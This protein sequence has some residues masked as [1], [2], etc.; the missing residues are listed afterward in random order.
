MQS[1]LSATPTRLSSHVNQIYSTQGIRGFW[2]GV[3]TTVARAVVLGA[4]NLGTYSTAKHMLGSKLGLLEDGVPLQLGSSIVAGLAIAST[5]SPIDFAR[6]RVMCRGAAAGGEAPVRSGFEI[7]RV[8]VRREGPLSLYK[9]FFPQWARMA[10][11][12]VIQ[13]LVWEKL[14]SLAGVRAV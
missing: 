5:T 10:P 11:Y 12:T 7:I 13:F 4:T 14:C 8:A 3:G 1:D 6:S 9:G 2:V